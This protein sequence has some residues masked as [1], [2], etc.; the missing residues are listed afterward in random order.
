MNYGQVKNQVLQLLNQYTVAGTHVALSYNNQQD[1]VNR[2]PALVN[3]A[4]LEIATTTRKIQRV[5]TLDYDPTAA[6]HP[7]WDEFGDRIR[8]ELPDDFYQFKTGDTFA[9]T[10]DGITLHTNRFQLEGKKYLLIPKKELEDGRTYTITYYRYPRLLGGDP[11]DEDE[12]DNES[13]TH[14]AVPFY[15]AAFLVIHDDAFLF[16]AFYNKYEDKL[17]KMGPGVSAEL[18]SVADSFGFSCGSVY[19]T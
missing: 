12:L 14:Y 8:F 13:E 16:S 7:A 5:L 11:A 9:V 3:D 1:Y 2:I 10:D 6:E 4:V 18:R 19:D 15:A 17:A